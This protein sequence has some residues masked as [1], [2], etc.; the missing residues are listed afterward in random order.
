MAEILDKCLELAE[1]RP[2]LEADVAQWMWQGVMSGVLPVTLPDDLD[3]P[4]L[5]TKLEAKD[6]PH[7][8]STSERMALIFYLLDGEAA[9]SA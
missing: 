6:A 4:D 9:E 1:L 3:D 7:V 5:L 2:E 8:L